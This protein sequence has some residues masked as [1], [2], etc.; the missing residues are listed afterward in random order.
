MHIQRLFA[1]LVDYDQRPFLSNVLCPALIIR[2][3]N[4]DF[5]PEKYVREF[6]KYLK[7]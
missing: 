5:V 7:I 1:E 4:D 6:E 2:G 3:R